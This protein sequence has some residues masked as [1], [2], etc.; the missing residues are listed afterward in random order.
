MKCC[1]STFESTTFDSLIKLNFRKME[2]KW[3]AV[4]ALYDTGKRP[5]EIVRDLHC[6]TMFVSGSVS[7][8]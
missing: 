6:N 3:A 1:L 8:P 5:V 2:G 4:A 7:K